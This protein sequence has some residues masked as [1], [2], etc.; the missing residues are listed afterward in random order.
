MDWELPPVLL[1]SD[2]IAKANELYG[3]NMSLEPSDQYRMSDTS[4]VQVFGSCEMDFAQTSEDIWEWEERMFLSRENIEKRASSSAKL[5][6]SEE[7]QLDASSVE[8]E[9]HQQASV[10]LSA[11]EERA[12][13]HCQ[14]ELSNSKKIKVTNRK[15]SLGFEKRSKK[16]RIIRRSRLVRKLS[17]QVHSGSSVEFVYRNEYFWDYSYLQVERIVALPLPMPCFRTDPNWY[18]HAWD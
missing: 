1:A 11:V 17:K 2:V 13:Q 10:R 9:Q 16:H 12:S 4:R 7:P 18:E 5:S 3:L 8:T 14:S 6:S 15:Y